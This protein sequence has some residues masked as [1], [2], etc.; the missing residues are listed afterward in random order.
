[1]TLASV[2]VAPAAPAGS[3]WTDTCDAGCY[4]R[5]LDGGRLA[6]QTYLT[7]PEAAFYL[8][9]THEQYRNP[10]KAFHGLVERHGLPRLYRGR[11]VLF[12]RRDL[13]RFVTA[14]QS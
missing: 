13:D 1:M 9:Y 3:E 12:L 5:R 10:L 11:R 4:C 6:R 7:F 8:G 14:G 2:D